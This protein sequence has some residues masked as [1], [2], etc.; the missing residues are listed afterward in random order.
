MRISSDYPLPSLLQKAV[1]LH[2]HSVIALITFS[3]N[4]Q[5]TFGFICSSPTTQ[6]RQ[7]LALSSSDHG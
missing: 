6:V 4:P 3:T 2:K 7:F 1:N 5:L